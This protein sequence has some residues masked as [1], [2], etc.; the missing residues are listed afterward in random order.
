MRIGEDIIKKALPAILFYVALAVA[1]GLPLF[2]A[3]FL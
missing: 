2:F 1:I 3:F